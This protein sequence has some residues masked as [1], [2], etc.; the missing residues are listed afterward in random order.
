MDKDML[1]VIKKHHEVLISESNKEKIE[2]INEQFSCRYAY[3]AVGLEGKNKIPY[4]EVSR[5]IQTGFS[6]QYSE[7]EKKEILN[8]YMTFKRVEEMVESNIPLTEER[9][10][11]LHEMMVHGIID[12][13][14]YR[15]VNIQ[16][17][18]AK[19]QPPDYVKVY[20]RMKK[21]FDTLDNYDDGI[22]KAVYAHASIAKIHPF[23]DGNGRLARLVMNYYL[24]RAH[25]L[26]I[27]IP[28]S[29]REDYIRYLESF[30]VDKDIEPLVSFVKELLKERYNQNIEKL[31]E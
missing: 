6:S 5:L 30:K 16:I 31:E 8:H 3:D 20:D 26:P 23:L 19:H 11:D 28:I 12:G 29:K 10:K 7:R 17:M 9:I 21:L 2:E 22:V 24:M 25:Y 4:E 13:G 14:V 1:G 18:S 15:N 27:S